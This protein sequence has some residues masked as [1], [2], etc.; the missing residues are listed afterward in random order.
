[1][2]V[3]RHLGIPSADGL[4]ALPVRRDNLQVSVHRVSDE[5]E[6]RRKIVSL[7]R[8]PQI[9]D[10]TQVPEPM[11]YTTGDKRPHLAI[12]NNSSS[13]NIKN[14]SKALL[15]IVYVWRRFEADSLAEYLK[16]SGVSGVAVY[17][18]GIDAAT[19]A[20]TQLLFDRGKIKCIVATVAFGMGVDK[21]DVRQVIHCTM[22]KSIE[23]YMQVKNKPSNCFLF[24][25]AYSNSSVDL[26]CLP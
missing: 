1:M 2:D 7:V 23:S 20:R 3:M 21:A 22:P 11:E 14:K 25:Y 12:K 10:P 6:R 9:F 26:I 19:R 4:V 16:G 5:D 15:T 24:F 18:A 13:S 8:N 17:H